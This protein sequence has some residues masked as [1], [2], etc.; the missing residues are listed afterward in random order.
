VDVSGPVGPTSASE[1]D[2]YSGGVAVLRM[3]GFGHSDGGV[4]V[5]LVLL[6]QVELQ[7]IFRSWDR[8]RRRG[9]GGR[10]FLLLSRKVARFG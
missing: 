8:I 3:V 2:V 4:D 9:V 10:H 5:E 7:R 6:L 1:V